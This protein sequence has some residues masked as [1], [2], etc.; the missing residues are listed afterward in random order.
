MD[1]AVGY[2]NISPW[3]VPGTN[4]ALRGSSRRGDRFKKC[5]LEQPDLGGCKWN[6]SFESV[7]I[8]C[9]QDNRNC[10]MV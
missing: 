10:R 1:N 8:T 5:E 3:K 4:S 9:L 2:K 6:L 7:A